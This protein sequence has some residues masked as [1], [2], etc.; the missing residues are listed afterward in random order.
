MEFSAV[1]TS[2]PLD[3]SP[4]QLYQASTSSVATN[5]TPTLA[6]ASE[7]IIAAAF[8]GLGGLTATGP[9]APWTL[10]SNGNGLAGKVAVAYQVVNS[11]AI[12]STTFPNSQ[13]ATESTGLILSYKGGISSGGSLSLLGFG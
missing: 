9:A 3:A 8:T 10:V 11:T 2:S 6:Q 13:G 5:N 4:G 12:I 1:A 7:L